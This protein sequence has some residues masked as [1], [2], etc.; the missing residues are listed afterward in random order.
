MLVTITPHQWLASEFYETMAAVMAE[1]M[2]TEMTED[3]ARECYLWAFCALSE[4]AGNC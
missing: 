2:D 1:E 4:P 3:E